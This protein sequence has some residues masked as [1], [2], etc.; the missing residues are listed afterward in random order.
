MN[1]DLYHCQCIYNVLDGLRDGLSHFSGPSRA[2]LIYAVGPEDPILVYDP[3]NLLQGHEPRFRELYL[4]S[5]AWRRPHLNGHVLKRFGYFQPE[6]NLE[7]A[8]LI[9]C[10]GRSTSLDYQMWF[11]EHHPDMC[12]TGP[13]QR[14]LEHAAW[15]L[16]NDFAASAPYTNASGYVLRGYATHAVRDYILDEINRQLGWDTPLHIYPLLDNV[17]GISRT[18]EEAAWPR[19]ELLF[20]EPAASNQLDY[21]ARFPEVERPTLENHK[22]I[23]KLLQASEGS[24]RK[25]VSDGRTIIG[26][27]GAELPEFSIVA[28]FRGRH[29]FLRLNETPICSFADGAFLS[30]S[31]QAKLVQVE[32]ALLE[33]HLEPAIRHRLFKIIAH[34]VHQAEAHKH[35]CTLV[36]DLHPEPIEIAGQRLDRA[37]DLQAAEALELAGSLS[38][39]DGALHI[40]ADLR[41]HRFACLLDGRAIAGESRARG[42]RYNSALRFTAVHAKL[43]VVVVSAD[44]PVSVIQEG[45]ELSAQCVWN[46][47]CGCVARPVPMERWVEGQAG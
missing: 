23:R 22:H 31:H 38:K 47:I 42:A 34:L 19:G 26:I 33:S 27:C 20:V 29:G 16:S 21:L 11:T 4:D 1:S 37:L 45:V 10:G 6:P 14:W 25:L 18:L 39:V 41:L 44:R 36:I 5:R 43:I 40:G 7:L 46:P 15:L 9:S 8:G 13:T 30:T 12:S 2:A 28:D 3:Q 35:G 32:E 24:R 17:L